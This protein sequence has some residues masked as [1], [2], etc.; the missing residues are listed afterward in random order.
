MS[1]GRNDPCPCGSGKKYK[2]CCA[3]RDAH[4]APTLSLLGRST[5]SE[6]EAVALNATHRSV[7]WEADVAPVMLVIES[8]PAARPAALILADRKSVV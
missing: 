6:V 1:I 8:E 3:M 2:H 4:A 5:I 7:P